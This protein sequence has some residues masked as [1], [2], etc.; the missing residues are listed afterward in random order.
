M[1]RCGVWN[2]TMKALRDPPTLF[3]IDCEQA[4]SKLGRTGEGEM[5]ERETP[6]QLQLLVFYFRSLRSISSLAWPSWGT[7]RSLHSTNLRSGS[8]FVS[9]LKLH[10]GGQGETNRFHWNRL[11]VKIYP[12][13]ENITLISL[14]SINFIRKITCI[15]DCPYT[16]KSR[17]TP[18]V[19]YYVKTLRC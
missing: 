16:R 15:K 6:S 4:L 1:Y 17:N 5:V 2:W 18:Y 13:T 9:L 7:A 19:V 8:I 12:Q 3:N 10:S 14:I 11:K